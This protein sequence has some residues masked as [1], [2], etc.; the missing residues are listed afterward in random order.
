MADARA[1]IDPGDAVAILGSLNAKPQDRRLKRDEVRPVQILTR[2]GFTPVSF[3][4][5]WGDLGV[6]SMAWRNDRA[7]ILYVAT[8]R[9]LFRMDVDDGCVESL[10]F[11]RCKDIHELTVIGGELWVANTGYDEAVAIDLETERV[12]RRIGLEKFRH[13]ISVTEQVEENV[14]TEQVDRFH[15]NQVFP[16][17]DGQLYALVHHVSGRQIIKKIAQK[18]IKS[19]GNG[20]VI[21]LDTGDAVPM[22]LKGPHTVRRVNGQY[23]LFD[24]GAATIR[25]YGPEWQPLETLPSAGWGRGADLSGD[26]TLFYAGISETRKRYLGLPGVKYSPNMVQIYSTERAE[27]V[28]EIVVSEW[29]EQIN[30][31][32][33]IPVDIADKLVAL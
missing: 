12:S 29:L 24:S 11:P 7:G 10:T 16:G 4:D 20:G 22:S 14:D 17:Y 8:D 21:C 31:V 1:L 32:Y 2:E 28:G 19:H 23:W 26:R 27:S 33:V 25:T 30:N 5:R 3:F 9:E 18:V 15:C 6:S 13:G